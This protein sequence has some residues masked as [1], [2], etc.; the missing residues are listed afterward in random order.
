MIS[1]KDSYELQSITPM[2]SNPY[3][4][5]HCCRLAD[6]K[7]S[8]LYVLCMC[9]DCCK[10]PTGLWDL[11]LLRTQQCKGTAPSIHMNQV[12]KTLPEHLKRAISRGCAG[13]WACAFPAQANA[14]TELEGR[15]AAAEP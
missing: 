4:D 9:S 11:L 3:S 1:L 8:L 2:T 12:G 7:M 14:N 10:A 5:C 6:T 13:R 15:F